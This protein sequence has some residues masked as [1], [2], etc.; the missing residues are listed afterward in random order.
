MTAITSAATLGTRVAEIKAITL[1]T[2][3]G[4]S[5]Q[6]LAQ[7]AIFEGNKLVLSPTDDAIRRNHVEELQSY[8]HTIS[9]FVR[10]PSGSF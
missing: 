6:E 9:P 7:A 10:C 2:S 8:M 3:N 1:S 5:V 4:L